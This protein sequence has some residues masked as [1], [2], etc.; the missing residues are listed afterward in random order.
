MRVFV[1][2]AIR[3]EEMSRKPRAVD[4]VGARVCD[5]QQLVPIIAAFGAIRSVFLQITMLRVTDP[6]SYTD[7]VH[8]P[9]RAGG[10]TLKRRKRRAPE[11]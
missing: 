7:F 11:L 1:N 2:A 10:R 3:A 8:S 9:G 5:P 6:R 4:K